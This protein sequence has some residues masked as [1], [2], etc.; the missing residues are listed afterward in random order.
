MGIHSGETVEASGAMEQGMAMADRSSVDGNPD[1][2][3]KAHAT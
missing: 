3:R 2:G 1:M